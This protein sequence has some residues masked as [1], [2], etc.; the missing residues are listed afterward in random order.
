MVYDKLKKVSPPFFI[1]LILTCVILLIGVC[2]YSE[3]NI[4]Q[5][6][7]NTPIFFKTYGSINY[8]PNEDNTF[9]LALI[10]KKNSNID[11]GIYSIGFEKSYI[12]ALDITLVKSMS[13]S[14]YKLWYL[15]FV[16][17]LTED[18]LV[19]EMPI[20][21][22]NISF[23]G[24]DYDIGSLALNIINDPNDL[25]SKLKLRSC[26]GASV[27]TDLANYHASFENITKEEISISSVEI[28]FFDF[29]KPLLNVGDNYFDFTGNENIIIEPSEIIDLD[30]D[31]SFCKKSGVNVY[32]V[33]PIVHYTIGAYN[34][35]AA[36]NYYTSGLNI[37]YDELKT[38]GDSLFIK[39]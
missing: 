21:I 5:A 4:G 29:A 39:R 34:Y 33:A 22:N 32:Y 30:I 2:N 36:L 25:F 24:S 28:P 15:T 10:T 20:V 12:K 7:D 26:A 14:D 38:I 11:S 35:I 18:A 31:L 23:N 13:Y 19:E 27:G 17:D 1:L 37:S 16:I 8:L 6:I 9:T 3:I